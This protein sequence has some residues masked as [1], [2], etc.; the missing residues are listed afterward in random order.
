MA[1]WRDDIWLTMKLTVF[2][3]GFVL[4]TIAVP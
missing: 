3:Y 2:C 4:A 1:S